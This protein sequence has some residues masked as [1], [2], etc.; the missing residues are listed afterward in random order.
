[1]TAN[2][3]SSFQQYPRHFTPTNMVIIAINIIVIIIITFLLLLSNILTISVHRFHNLLISDKPNLS[4][5]SQ[6][7]SDAYFQPN[8]PVL[9]NVDPT[10]TM[11]SSKLV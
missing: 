10:D 7:H 3:T 4:L 5:K 6:S 9:N 2:E 11:L 1:M 8:E